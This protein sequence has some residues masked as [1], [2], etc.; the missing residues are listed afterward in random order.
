MP[1][2]RLS[3]LLIC[4]WAHVKIVISYRIVSYRDN[5]VNN[6][7]HWLTNG[8]LLHASICKWLSATHVDSCRVQSFSNA[9]NRL[10]AIQNKRLC[11]C[12][13]NARRA[14][15]VEILWACFDWAI[16]KKLCLCTGTMRAHC[17]LKSCKMPHRCSMD[18]IWKHLQAVN[19]LQ[20]HSRSLP[21]LP[22]DRPHTISY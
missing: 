17:Q 2:G 8:I 9:C 21:L 16:D 12:R 1:C 4:F 5:Q 6:G 19:D 18:C 10:L 14:M 22:F 15:S 11:Y 13:G 20:S 3:W 7:H